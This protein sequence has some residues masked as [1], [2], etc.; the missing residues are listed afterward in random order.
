M[1]GRERK[2]RGRRGPGESEGRE[3]TF[4]ITRTPLRKRSEKAVSGTRREI[5]LDLLDERPRG[6]RSAA[7]EWDLSEVTLSF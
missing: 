6:A 2:K 5:T 3:G 4:E 7:S 1:R